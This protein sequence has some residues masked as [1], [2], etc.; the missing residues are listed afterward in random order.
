MSCCLYMTMCYK[1]LR[2][3]FLYAVDAIKTCTILCSQVTVTFILIF[4]SLLLDEL[5]VCTRD[6][7]TPF[8]ITDSVRMF[9]LCNTLQSDLC[10]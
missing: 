2:I 4:S 10:K 6:I 8:L 1:R 5:L 7:K 9:N 3:I